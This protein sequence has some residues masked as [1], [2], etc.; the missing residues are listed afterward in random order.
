MSRS[1]RWQPIR[2][3]TRW[4]WFRKDGGVMLRN[5]IYKA[6]VLTDF[7]HPEQSDEKVFRANIDA[8]VKGLVSEPVE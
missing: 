3:V 1:T 7:Y 4:R 2:C 8:L 6:S 5:G